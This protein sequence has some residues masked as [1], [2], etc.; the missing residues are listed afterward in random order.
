MDA[1]LNSGNLRI[2]VGRTDMKSYALI[3]SLYFP[4]NRFIL[5]STV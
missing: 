2:I 4:R 5:P 3:C 1:R